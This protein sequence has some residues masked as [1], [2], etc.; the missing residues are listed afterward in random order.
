MSELRAADN[1]RVKAA[2]SAGSY[3]TIGLHTF[4]KGVL[5][6]CLILPPDASISLLKRQI[7]YG[8]QARFRAYALSRCTSV[9]LQWKEWGSA[10]PAKAAGSLCM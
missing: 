4:V 7:V 1:A 3:I 9:R 10:L 6:S 2:E 8:M 5:P